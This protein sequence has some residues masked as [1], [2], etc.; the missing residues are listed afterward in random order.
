MNKPCSTFYSARI[1]IISALYIFIGFLYWEKRWEGS[2]KKKTACYF[3]L[4]LCLCLLNK[5]YLHIVHHCQVFTSL[6]NYAVPLMSV[7]L[8]AQ[9]M[10]LL[11]APSRNRG[12]LARLHR[13]CSIK[14]C[15]AWLL[16]NIVSLGQQGSWLAGNKIVG[17]ADWSWSQEM[18]WD[19]WRS[20]NKDTWS[21]SAWRKSRSRPKHELS[22]CTCCPWI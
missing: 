3:F 14:A 9:W 20:V 12:T 8:L 5:K 11:K 22:Q 6:H 21:L 10:C 4:Q 18:E 17:G 7:S 16:I 19:R 1:I 13:V 15:C 2:W